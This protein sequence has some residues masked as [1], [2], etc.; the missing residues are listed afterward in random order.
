MPNRLDT[1]LSSIT[2][3]LSGFCVVVIV[4]GCFVCK[5]VLDSNLEQS[6]KFIGLV[7]VLSIIGIV[8]TVIVLFAIFSRDVL[9]D[10]MYSHI[11]RTLGE[12]GNQDRQQQRNYLKKTKVQAKLQ[13]GETK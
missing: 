11:I 4:L 10:S 1:L 2:T 12:F 3:L 9:F 6:D 5:Y 7:I 13:K 8:F